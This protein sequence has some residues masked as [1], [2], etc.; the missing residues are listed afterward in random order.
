MRGAESSRTI[1]RGPKRNAVAFLETLGGAH[2]ARRP[3]SLRK[4]CK[5]LVKVYTCQLNI[6]SFTCYNQPMDR[7][8]VAGSRTWT[9]FNMIEAALLPVYQHYGPVI[10][11]HGDCK[12][13]DTIANSFWVQWNL[14]SEA[15][16][17]DWENH[18]KR[19]G[20]LR[21]KQMIDLQPIGM[22]AFIK[23]PSVGT[24]MTMK[25]C[26]DRSIPVATYSCP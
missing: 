13:A 2:L 1:G 17:A 10:L 26:H 16:P 12:G 14:P 4:K 5:N 11:I 6:H 19:A 20:Y 7:F 3:T 15:Y 23:G 22:L 25:L 18:G 8:L 9:D 21:N 24:R